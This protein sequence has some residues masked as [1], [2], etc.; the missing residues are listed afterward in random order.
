MIEPQQSPRRRIYIVGPTDG[1]FEQNQGRFGRA[2]RDLYDAGFEPIIPDPQGQP[3]PAMYFEADG[4]ATLD[5]WA[6]DRIAARRVR[7]A[8]ALSIPVRPLAAWLGVLD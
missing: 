8:H 6:E 2:A 7:D 5:N 1:Y 4:L 3:T